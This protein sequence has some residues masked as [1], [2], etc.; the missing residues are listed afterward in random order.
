MT[1]IF[2]DIPLKM[3]MKNSPPIDLHWG[4]IYWSPRKWQ[5]LLNFLQGAGAPP[6]LHLRNINCASMSCDVHEWFYCWEP[7]ECNCTACPVLSS[8]SLFRFLSVIFFIHFKICVTVC[9]SIICY[10]CFKYK[11]LPT[12]RTVF[13]PKQIVSL[14]THKLQFGVTG[15]KMVL[16]TGNTVSYI[17]NHKLDLF[18]PKTE[19]VRGCPTHPACNSVR[20][21]LN[22]DRELKILTAW[23]SQLF[24]VQLT[25]WIELNGEMLKISFIQKKFAFG[26]FSILN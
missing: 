4:W 24:H 12:S 17:Q 7:S 13:F 3:S 23:I 9:T 22:R 20:K 1:L 8:P 5:N 6:P 21:T 10:Y 15:H 11:Y 26:S 18:W 25:P 2:V 19:W 14:A 16:L